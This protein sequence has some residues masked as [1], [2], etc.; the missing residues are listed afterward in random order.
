M[1]YFLLA[2]SLAAVSTA[3]AQD[4]LTRAASPF[5][6]VRTSATAE[7]GI[8]PDWASVS[9]SFSSVGPTTAE[10][11]RL[12]ARRAD[13]LR[14]ALQAIGIPRDSLVTT[15]AFQGYRSRIESAGRTR[16]VTRIVEGQQVHLQVPETTYRAQD[17][18]EVRMSNVRMLAPAIDTAMAHGITEISPPRFMATNV[19]SVR[20]SLLREAAQRARTHA[21]ALAGASNGRLGRLILITTERVFIDESRVLGI[22]S[23]GMASTSYSETEIIRPNLRLS[24]TVLGRWEF[25]PR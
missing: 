12:V 11:G 1:R 10:A 22:A 21:E 25:V 13:S 5:P 9:F 8:R 24:V 6:E 19:D 3:Q 4:S 16:S 2:V 18:I 17:A 20:T 14:R 15:S 23:S 7:R